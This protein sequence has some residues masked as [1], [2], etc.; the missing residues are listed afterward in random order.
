MKPST[1]SERIIIAVPLNR[2]P[3]Y[4]E[5]FFNER[6]TAAGN[7]ATL[8]LT[9]P[10]LPP[11]M[12]LEHNVLATFV[13]EG[14]WNGWNDSAE[15]SWQPEGGGPFPTF[16]GELK[17]LAD[18]D[19]NSAWLAIDGSYVP[20]GGA[21]GRVFDATVGHSIASATAQQLLRELKT[22]VERYHIDEER[23]KQP[24]SPPSVPVRGVKPSVDTLT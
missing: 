5:R 4:L 11:G 18:E 19:Y 9:V 6:R 2:A 3:Y 20:P 21:A 1:L 22:A 17:I 24:A 14:T 7:Q 12:T 8:E 16:H 15:V 13:R 23:A 10:G